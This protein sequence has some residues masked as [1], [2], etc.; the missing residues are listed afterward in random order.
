MNEKVGNV[1]FYGMQQD[2]FNKPYSDDTATM[3]DK[4][5]RN[6]I[7]KQYQRAQDLLT[8]K[9]TELNALANALLENEVLLK[10]DVERLIGVR[11]NGIDVDEIKDIDPTL[12]NTVDV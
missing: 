11:P 10:S 2:Q 4:E 5:V 3:I 8:E 1:S 9:R 12:D 7:D 6:M